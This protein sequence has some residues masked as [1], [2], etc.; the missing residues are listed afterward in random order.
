MANKPKR[1]CK[2][3]YCAELVESGYCDKHK[4]HKRNHNDWSRWYSLPRW[5]KART[6][7]LN[8]HPLCVECHKH[9]T[10]TTAT[11]VDHIVDHKG[12]LIL[13]WDSNNWQ[14]LCKRCHDRKTAK[15]S[16]CFDNYSM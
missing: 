8:E 9:N 4:K 7:Y 5:R 15:T 10:L 11:V 16:G 13:F 6:M 2:Y 1:P 12:D 3:P 14:S